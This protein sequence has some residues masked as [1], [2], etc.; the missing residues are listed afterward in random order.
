M[1][2]WLPALALA[3]SSV[4]EF[5][6]GGS[7]VALDDRCIRL[8]PDAPARTGSAF[9]QRSFTLEHPFEVA[10]SLV[11]GDRD[12]LGAD[13]IVFVLTPGAPETGWRGEGMGFAGLVPSLGIEIDT[14]QN[15][16][17]ND[18]AG[19]HLAV[20]RDGRSWHE[21]EPVE[22]GQLEDGERHSFVVQW[23]PSSGL[24]VQLDGTVRARVPADEVRQ[25]VG[26]GEL[27][28]GFTAATGRKT[29]RHDVCL[30]LQRVGRR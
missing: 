20:M 8:T 3:Q 17:L 10:V 4:N 12:E 1:M 16:H 6:L 24:I 21:D 29:N 25:T 7:A 19:D 11:L 15:L 22:V 13:G 27:R 2:W 28:W 30:E 23:T 14:Y 18:P 9:C 26:A 5:D